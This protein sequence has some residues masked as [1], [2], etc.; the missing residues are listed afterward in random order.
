VLLKLEPR[1]DRELEVEVRHSGNLPEGS[2]LRGITASP[3]KVKLRG[4]A[5][6]L[7][8]LQK[9]PTEII[10]LDG[11][12]ESFTLPQVE[13]QI[14]DRKVD[15][16]EGTVSVTFDIGE[17]RVEKSVSNVPVSASDGT[18]MRPETVNVTVYGERSAINQLRAENMRLVLDVAQDGSFAPRLELPADLKG[19]VEL[20][21]TNPAVFTR[22]SFF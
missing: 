1:L 20:R 22:R 9:A 6:H 10:P 3:D 13:I 17:E 8:A 14:A 16:I 18:Q 2:T 7:G 12:K 19:R 11:R 21:S 4:P 5:S 15:L